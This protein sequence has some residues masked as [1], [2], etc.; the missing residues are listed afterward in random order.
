MTKRLVL[1]LAAALAAMPATSA[2]SARPVPAP[3]EGRSVGASPNAAVPA[4]G[5]ALS[6]SRDVHRAVASPG[7]RGDLWGVVVVSLDAGDT[8]VAYEPTRELE[9]ASNLKLFT[10]AAALHYLGSQYRYAT[11]LAGTGPIRGGVLEGDL[12]LYGTGDPTP[13]GK[14]YEPEQGAYEALADSIAAMGVRRIAGDVVGDASYFEGQPVG[15]GWEMRYVTHTYAAQGSALS[16]NDNVATLRVRPADS[17]GAPPQVTV[18]PAGAIQMVNEARTVASGRSWIEVERSG[19]DAPIVVRGQIQRG[20]SGLWRAVPVVDP[21]RF[22]ASVMRDLLAERGITVVGSVRAVHDAARSPITAT[23]V[24]APAL[25]G[26]PAIQVLA[27]H[28]SPPLIDIIRVINQRSH[29]VYAEAVLRTV[30]RVTTGSGSVDGGQRAVDAMLKQVGGGAASMVHMDDGSGL[31]PLNRVTPMAVADLLMFVAR[32]PY[33]DDFLTTLPEAAHSRGLRRMQHTPAAGNLRAKTGTIEHVSALS[34]Y[35]R[36]K[37]GERL[38]FSIISNGV[39]STWKAKRIEDRIG[40]RLAAF[41]R[42]V[43]V[44]RPMA[45]APMPNRASDSVPALANPAPA[46]VA[47][48]GAAPDTAARI[49]ASAAAESASRPVTY[50]IQ[51]G[52]TLDGIAKR[53]DTSVAAL[54]NANPGVNPRRLIPGRTIRLPSTLD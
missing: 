1:L 54:R 7:W 9:P 39:P 37:N 26:G 13:S 40:A 35:V 48:A 12:V 20:N 23:R 17:V 52:D 41:D 22:A 47:A 33:F 50:T 36:A 8:L 53:Y 4:E 28:H 45:A 44:H 32:S 3:P 43:P 14:F 42:P 27:V 18:L 11:Y 21:A 19:Y 49:S 15:S 16:Y 5:A 24:F 10:T 2:L 25:E 29:N 6:L 46:E 31:S 34:G 38:V 51:S 30:G